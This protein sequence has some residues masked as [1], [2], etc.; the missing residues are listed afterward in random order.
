MSGSSPS[1][2]GPAAVPA[3]SPAAASHAVGTPPADS[4]AAV[5]SV[6]PHSRALSSPVADTATGRVPDDLLTVTTRALETVFSGLRDLATAAAPL[7]SEEPPR[8]ASLATLRPP[9]GQLL[10]ECAD[11]VIGAGVAV[12]SGRLLDQDRHLEWWWSRPGGT[13]ESLRVNLDPTAPDVYD[14]VTEEWFAAATGS[15]LPFVAGPYVDYACT[16]DYALTLAHPVVHRGEVVAVAAADLPVRRLEAWTLPAVGAA[17]L[18]RPQVLV[19]GSGRVVLSTD[20][21][22]LPG[23]RADAGRLAGGRTVAGAP[24]VPQWWLVDLDL[25]GDSAG[26]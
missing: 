11:L 7:W 12:G 18:G 16:N 19:N 23:G 26:A 5:S 10:T 2:G 15:G 3:Y 14:F 20:P 8:V 9:I 21:A 22:L 1:G 25:A 13:T 4:S 17:T 6:A 24:P